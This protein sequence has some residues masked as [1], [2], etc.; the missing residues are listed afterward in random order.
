MYKL[1]VL[2]RHCVPD[3]FAAY[4]REPST[5]RTDTMHLRPPVHRLM[6]MTLLFSILSGNDAGA[7][8]GTALKGDATRGQALFNGKGICHYCHGIDGVI[9]KKASLKPETAAAIA[10]QAA[11]APDLRN[12]AAQIL[13]DNKARFRVIREGHPGSGMFPDSTLNDQEITDILAYLAALRQSAST[14]SKSPY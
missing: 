14:P 6:L 5:L 12:R 8:D 10:R 7:T 3:R 1:H 11:V 13:K 2:P 9:D 4:C